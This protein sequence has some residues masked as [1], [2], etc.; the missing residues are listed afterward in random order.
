MRHPKTE[1]DSG[2]SNNA[3]HDVASYIYL[4]VAPLTTAGLLALSLLVALTESRLLLFIEHLDL[5]D[6]LGWVVNS[7]GVLHRDLE[8]FGNPVDRYGLI[9]KW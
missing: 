6:V 4:C 7:Y 5:V 2:T 8:V 3:P 9:R 1:D